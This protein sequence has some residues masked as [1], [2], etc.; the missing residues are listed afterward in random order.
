MRVICF[1]VVL[2]ALG[3]TASN[4]AAQGSSE[5][6]ART[7]A[8]AASFSKFKSLSKEKHGDGLTIDKFFY[9]KTR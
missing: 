6:A 2:A 4:V 3:A 8:I 1:G 7:N 9:E 5:T